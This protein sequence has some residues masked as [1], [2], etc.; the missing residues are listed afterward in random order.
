MRTDSG[1]SEDI[2]R[3]AD[4]EPGTADAGVISEAAGADGGPRSI[5]AESRPAE[6]DALPDAGQGV[7]GQGVAGQ[8]VAG[9][10]GGPG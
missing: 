7:A 4:T 6:A 8:S 5:E 9:M 10:D 1:V 3:D 2:T